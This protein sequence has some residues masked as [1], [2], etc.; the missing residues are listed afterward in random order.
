MKIFFEKKVIVTKYE[1]K[2]YINNVQRVNND[3]NY[4]FLSF[5]KKNEIIDN[6]VQNINKKINK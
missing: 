6:K 3:R 1:K 5:K 2:E 4:N